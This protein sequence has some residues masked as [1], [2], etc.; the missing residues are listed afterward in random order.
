MNAFLEPTAAPARVVLVT[1]SAGVGKSTLIGKFL[2]L[3]RGRGRTVAVLA[4][5]PESPLT[6]GA[7]LGD[8][9]RMPARPEDEGIFIRSLAAKSGRG[10]VADDVDVMI[11]LLEAYCF[12]VI[13]VER[14]GVGQ[15][16]SE[17]RRLTD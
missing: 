13:L 3:L 15:G 17:M 12:D 9:F 16:D 1:G 7:L 6:G 10:V 2:D 4:S 8:R 11:R 5:D 14:V